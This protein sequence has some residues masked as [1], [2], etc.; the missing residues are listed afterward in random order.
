MYKAWPFFRVTLDMIAMVV[1]KADATTVKLYEEKL[2][3]TD[4]K[5]IGADLRKAF[6]LARESLLSIIGNKSVLGSGASSRVP[7]CLLTCLGS[8]LFAVTRASRSTGVSPLSDTRITGNRLGYAPSC[9]KCCV[10]EEGTSLA[11]ASTCGASS[12]PRSGSQAPGGMLEARLQCVKPLL[13]SLPPHH[14]GW[15]C[16]MQCSCALQAAAPFCAACPV[17]LKGFRY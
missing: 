2:V 16:C 17:R 3:R 1:A 4:L 15:A 13:G 11:S 7:I 10:H 9:A 6:H 12:G 8:A 14:A 5:P